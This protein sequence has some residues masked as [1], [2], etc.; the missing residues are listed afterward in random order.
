VKQGEQEVL[1]ARD[2]VGQESGATQR[3]INR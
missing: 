3:G 1:H 2:S